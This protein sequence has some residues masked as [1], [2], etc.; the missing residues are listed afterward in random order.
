[1][2]H[3][4]NLAPPSPMHREVDALLAEHAGDGPTRAAILDLVRSAAFTALPEPVGRLVLAY[5]VAAG[6]NARRM[7]WSLRSLLVE[8]GFAAGDT[9]T[10]AAWVY[11]Y[12]EEILSEG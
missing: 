7:A 9:R 12:G 3:G 10:K 4:L 6:P 11:L 1:M 5:V 2:R 8:P